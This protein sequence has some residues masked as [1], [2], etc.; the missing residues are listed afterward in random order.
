[1]ETKLIF[2]LSSGGV[3]SNKS[4]PDMEGELTF[5]KLRPACYTYQF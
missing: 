5:N 3:S 2:T 1:M 4:G